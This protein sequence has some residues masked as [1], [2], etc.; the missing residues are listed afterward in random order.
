MLTKLNLDVTE[1]IMPSLKSVG[2][3]QNALINEKNYLLRTYIDEPTQNK[4]KLN[5]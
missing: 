1:I 5:F 3:F 4:E 2:Q